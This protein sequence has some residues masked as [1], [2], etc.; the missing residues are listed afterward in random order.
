MARDNR[1]KDQPQRQEWKPHW[2]LRCLHKAWMVIFTSAKVAFGAAATVALI[3]VVCIFA[4]L[5]ILGEYLENDILPS[6]SLVLEE[7]DMDSP[8][9]VYS[10]NEN[11][12]IELLQE[13][14]ASTDWKKADYKDI[15]QALIHAAVA[16]ED[17][18]FYEHQGVDWVTT[19]KAFANMFF[20]SDT[21]GGSSI[22]Q[23]LIKN[24]TGEDSVTVQR[25]VLE[26]FRATLVE[27]NYNKE[28][29]IEEY[30]NSIYMGQGC[31]GVKSAAAAYFGKELQSLTIAECASLISITNNPSLFDPYNDEVYTFEGEQR[32]GMQRNR[33][34]QMLVLGQ[35]LSQGY[36]TQEE[37]DEAVAQ[38]LVLKSSIAEEDQWVICSNAECDYEGL[39][40][41]FQVSDGLKCPTCG[42]TPELIT[43]ASQEVYPYFV[44]AL[45]K[46][47]AK[48]MAAHDGI[49]EWNYD[50]WMD[51]LDRI[52]RGGYHI[53]A[54]I[55]TKVQAQVDKIYKDLDNIPDTRSAQQ[56]QS[57][58]VVIDNSTGDIVAMAGGVG[59]DKVHFGLNRA[60]QSE[61]QSGS[62]IKPISIYAPGFEQ[63]TI[64]P[65]T[66][67]KDLPMEYTGGAWPR[68]DDR[69]YGYTST[70]F[71]GIEDSVNAVAAN[72]LQKIGT[73]YG[74]EFAKNS[75]GLSTLTDV[76]LQFSSLALG[77]QQYGVTVRDMACAFA[78]FPNKG[79]YRE[80][81]LYTKVYNS[82]GQIVLDKEQ[83][84]R[85][86]LGEKAINYINYCLTNAAAA[87]TG[88]GADFYTVDVAG[89]TGSTS[90]FR[91]RWFCGYT[92]Y[93]TAAVWCGYDTPE[94]IN[95]I[96]GS[97]NPASRLW[98]KVLEPLHEGLSN[99]RMYDTSEMVS[100]SV[101]LDTGKIATDACR[102][103]IRGG[104][105]ETV[106]VYPEDIP[107]G[108]CNKHIVLD[109]C[110]TGNG[111]ANE[112]CAHFAEVDTNVTLEK[113]ALLKLTFAQIQE[114][115]KAED[116]GLED[117]Y[118]NNNYVY[119]IDDN[120]KDGAFKGFHN[121]INLT[122]SAPYQVCTIHTQ[123]AWEEYQ[124]QLNPPV[125]D[126]NA[127]T[128]PNQ[129]AD[130][131]Q[132]TNPSQTTTPNQ[133]T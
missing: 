4:F 74:Y 82:K 36:I 78:T 14:Y 32:N 42:T 1:K 98:R 92:G 43:D 31:R 104:R 71:T 28:I 100:V 133:T 114:L 88:A 131:E 87:G 37:Y 22:T 68:N 90:S 6:A 63:G 53:Y 80:G 54:T 46:E 10:V 118:L 110:T 91:D 7:Y 9:Y 50:I 21:V 60:T 38:E 123:K 72:T 19:I 59:D 102:T 117:Q 89:K 47:V 93:Y 49:T 61:L 97:Y 58:I 121:D 69:E 79:T 73:N 76:D 132:P 48:D 94:T 23:Q 126:P 15:P 33:Y 18:R 81:R 99:I 122:E 130:P 101:C 3:G 5:G 77:A 52:N 66:V 56:L 129:P 86:I 65:A 109:H 25:K 13:L 35:M 17:K 75:F 67:I 103:D 84:S 11:G 8:S 45:L 106:M 62:S 96:G 124:L 95:L 41:T 107:N 105:T 113:K 83:E 34:R 125:E 119:L 111:V 26:F 120:G 128:T 40:K 70:I 55:D 108:T 57:A 115:L 24:K 27:K 64:S 29:I 51:Y 12:D 127:P 39:R 2:V 30:L 44:D 112:Y 16:I 116:F 20:G 85:E